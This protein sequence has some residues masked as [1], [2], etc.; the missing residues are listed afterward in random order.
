MIGK[1][2]FMQQLLRCFIYDNIDNITE[3]QIPTAKLHHA[4][5]YDNSKPYSLLLVYG[6][7]I[8]QKYSS[9]TEEG[10]HWW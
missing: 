10:T 6:V 1:L 7:Y 2:G 4:H 8:W 5:F 9:Q 3:E